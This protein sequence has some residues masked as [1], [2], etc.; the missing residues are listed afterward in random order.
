MTI[1]RFLADNISDPTLVDVDTVQLPAGTVTVGGRQYVNSLLTMDFDSTGVGGLD[2]GSRAADTLYYLY[3][4]ISGGVPGLIASIN[5]SSPTGF[6]FATQVGKFRTF[7][8]DSD[9]AATSS[10]KELSEWEAY[11]PFTAQGFG[12]IT[13]VTTQWR[14]NKGSLE[15][16]GGFTAGTTNASVALIGLPNE[17]RTY[18]VNNAGQSS[19]EAYIADVGRDASTTVKI[20]QIAFDNEPYLRFGRFTDGTPTNVLATLTGGGVAGSG[21]R[22]SFSFSVPIAE[23]RDLY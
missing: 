8:N 13:N 6:T 15:V 14:R 3:V 11:T 7:R 12:A 22:L 2:T 4:V 21:E 16:K 20:T 19:E 23:F 5:S 10:S 1:Q 9:I 17:F 18:F